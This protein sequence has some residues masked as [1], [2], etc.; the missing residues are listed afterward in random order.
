M[1]WP[2]AE[3]H[4]LRRKLCQAC[5]VRQVASRLEEDME[6]QAARRRGSSEMAA[7]PRRP[8]RSDNGAKKKRRAGNSLRFAKRRA[9]ERCGKARRPR[10]RSYCT[11]GG[12]SGGGASGMGRGKWGQ[13]G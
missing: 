6:A 1:A 13:R 12:A 4:T 3:K 7:A 11:Q 5:S 10:I 9:Q 2:A 8:R